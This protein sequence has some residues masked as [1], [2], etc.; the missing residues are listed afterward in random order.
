MRA[1]FPTSMSANA[2]RAST[3]G[4]G[5]VQSWSDAVGLLLVCRVIVIVSASAW[6][7]RT[8]EHDIRAAMRADVAHLLVLPSAFAGSDD[9]DRA[10]A[11]AFVLLADR[12]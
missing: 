12:H 9:R 10:A 3:Q 7:R 2:R 11:N 1:L 5:V 4:A 8:D 6:F